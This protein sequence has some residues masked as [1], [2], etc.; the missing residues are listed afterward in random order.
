MATKNRKIISFLGG[1]LKNTSKQFIRNIIVGLIAFAI[2]FCLL[3]VFTE[4][5]GIYYITSSII[6]S[7]CGGLANYT[8]ATLWVF[9]KKKSKNQ[10]LRLLLFTMIG[11]CG[12]AFTTLLLWSFTEFVHFHYLFSK[13]LA[14]FLVF[15]CNFF[16]RKYLLYESKIPWIAK[17]LYEEEKMS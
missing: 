16:A 3:W 14:Q 15:I 5:L 6:A 11:A 12:L 17:A 1:D 2:D 4:F 9:K 10:L 13:I 7:L 8:L